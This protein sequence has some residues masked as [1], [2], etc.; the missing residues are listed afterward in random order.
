MDNVHSFFFCIC[1]EFKGICL[2]LEVGACGLR[3]GRVD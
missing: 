2:I 1:T 3:I